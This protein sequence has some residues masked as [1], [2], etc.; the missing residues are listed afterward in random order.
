MATHDLKTWPKYFTAVL[1][2]DKPFEIRRNDRDFCSGDLVRLREWDPVTEKYTGR[3]LVRLIT[4]VTN[5]ADLDAKDERVFHPAYVVLGLGEASRGQVALLGEVADL[6]R[7]AAE[8]DETTY[9]PRLWLARTLAAVKSLHE[10]LGERNQAMSGRYLVITRNGDGD[11][12]VDFYSKED[13]ES[14]LNR[15]WWGPDV[16]WLSDADLVREGSDPQ[17]WVGDCVGIILGPKDAAVVVPRVA[18]K[19]VRVD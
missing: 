8:K 17:Y 7:D 16:R 11:V 10:L 13:L 18:E 15:S 3:V 12:S 14:S 6:L 1:A 4:C 9:W 5:A 2:G 19:V